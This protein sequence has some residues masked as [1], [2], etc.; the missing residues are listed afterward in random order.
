MNID[1][2]TIREVKEIS[3][4]IGSKQQQDKTRDYGHA[5]LVADR[6]FVYVGDVIVS[7]DFAEIKNAKNIRYWG[8]KNGLGEL[9]LN[10]PQ[11]ETK[12]DSCGD[13]DVPMRAVISIHRTDRN[14]WN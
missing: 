4:L 8:T 14:L 9:V 12:L 13:L 7:G 11:E 6:G 3:N 10:G 5:I 2:L 1:D